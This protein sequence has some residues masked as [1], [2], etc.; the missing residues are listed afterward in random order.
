MWRSAI[1]EKWGD[2]CELSCCYEYC[3]EKKVNE[4]LKTFRDL[5]S[6]FLEVLFMS[7]LPVEIARLLVFQVLGSLAVFGGGRR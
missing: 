5:N 7:Q 1:L 2:V 6:S 4:R 3:E